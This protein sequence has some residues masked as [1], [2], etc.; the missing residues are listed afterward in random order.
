MPDY[1]RQAGWK[2]GLER[3]GTYPDGA[4]ERSAAAVLLGEFPQ[5]QR[6]AERAQ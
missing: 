4:I 6:A 2:I 3:V 1:L 5:Q